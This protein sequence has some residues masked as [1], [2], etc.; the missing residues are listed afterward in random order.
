MLQGLDAFFKEVVEPIRQEVNRQQDA[1]V[2]LQMENTMLVTKLNKLEHLEDERED[3][4]GQLEHKRRLCDLYEERIHELDDKVYELEQKLDKKKR[5]L[6]ELKNNHYEQ[7]VK[8]TIS[9][10]EI[11]QMMASW[12]EAN[13]RMMEEELKEN[14]EQFILQQIELYENQYE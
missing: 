6:D 5:K 12:H 2:S 9:D 10:Y 11:E 8:K 3:L 1:N 13:H 14:E 4:R 7:W